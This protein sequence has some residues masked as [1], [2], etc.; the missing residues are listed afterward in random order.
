MYH[1]LVPWVQGGYAS[2][3]GQSIGFTAYYTG[4]LLLLTEQHRSAHIKQ[5]KNIAAIT[6]LFRS[7]FSKLKMGTVMLA[8]KPNDA[9]FYGLQRIA[10]SAF[11]KNLDIFVL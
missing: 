5:V 4:L 10:P 6:C 8:V 11:G 2:P 7:Y 9:R 1:R 3:K